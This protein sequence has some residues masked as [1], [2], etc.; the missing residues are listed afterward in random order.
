MRRLLFKTG[1][2][3]LTLLLIVVTL[4]ACTRL[5]SPVIKQI[6]QRDAKVGYRYFPNLAE[7]VYNHE[8]DKAILIRTNSVGFRG[9]EWALE[10]PEGVRR[11]AV[12]GDSFVAAIAVAEEETLTGRLEALLNEKT[13]LNEQAGDRAAPVKW[14]VMNF[15][16]TG[17][18]TGQQ[19]V[20]YREIVSRYQPDIVVV[21]FGTSSDVFDNSAELA[22]NPIL[23]FDLDEAGELHLLPQTKGRV[24]ASRSLN[25]WSRF[26]VWQKGKV[27][28]LIKRSRAS[29]RVPASRDLIYASNEPEE[30]RRAWQITGAL[31][32]AFRDETSARGTQLVVVAIP[33][34]KQIYDD[35]FALL[36]NRV[37]DSMAVDPAHPDRR[38]SQ[39]CESLDIPYLSLV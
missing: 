11:I 33:S 32:K 28:R 15:G 30:F 34:A 20:L 9:P 31:F 29:A 39:L 16:V 12:F 7:H 8:S 22:T 17:S 23:R 19:L 5:F 36:R 1:E 2:T 24:Q 4:E 35:Q 10:K 21:G 37:A 18:S 14:E 6:A 26:Y 25:A 3:L 27:N 13:G 38:L